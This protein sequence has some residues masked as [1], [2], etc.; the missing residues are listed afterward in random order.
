MS[1]PTDILAGAVA[2]LAV[3][4]FFAGLIYWRHTRA[5]LARLKSFVAAQQRPVAKPE[6]GEL[7]GIVLELNRRLRSGSYGQRLQ[8]ET[9]APGWRS[10]PQSSFL[11]AWGPPCS[12]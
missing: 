4:V 9:V 7:P 12:G 2:G 10:P 3:L 5:R 1:M 8:R 11:F 6:G